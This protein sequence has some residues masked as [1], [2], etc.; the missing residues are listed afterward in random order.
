MGK[1][2]KQQPSDPG[3]RKIGDN[4]KARFN[5]QIEETLECGI[6]LKGT[7]VKS[8]KAG[9]I[10]FIDSFVLI[11]DDEFILHGLHIT[12]YE[13]G[14]I[15]NHDPYRN[16]KLLA[17]KAEIIKIRRKVDERGYSVIPLDFHLKNGLVKV[18]IGIGKGKKLHDKRDSIKQRDISRAVDYEIKNR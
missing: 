12:P 9:K 5:Y 14:N 17:H 7:E 15:N 2:K 8:I 11:K 10:S 16:K 1:K 4:R 3:N 18:T 6:E 13:F